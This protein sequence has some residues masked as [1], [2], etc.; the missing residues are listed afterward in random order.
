MN[1]NGSNNW[2][3]PFSHISW[4]ER[5]L[6]HHSN[7]INVYR[8]DDI[9]FEVDRVRQSDSLTILCCREYVMG[10]TL[11]YRAINEFG[12]VNLIYIGGGWSGYTGEAKDYCLEN[13]I[14]LYVTDEMSGALWKNEYWDYIKSDKD[15][16]P[17][18]F[19]RG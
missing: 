8:R 15:G 12:K 14:G 3:V 19:H 10:L 18:Y 17:T 11:V 4:F 5:L 6:K 16:N 1:I 2:N 13:K 9:I 7:V